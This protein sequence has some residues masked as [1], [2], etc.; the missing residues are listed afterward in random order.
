MCEGSAET[1]RKAYAV[2]PLPEG[3]HRRFPRRFIP[4]FPSDGHNI[5]MPE[6]TRKAPPCRMLSSSPF[7]LRG[8]RRP[9]TILY[10]IRLQ[11]MMP[12]ANKISCTKIWYFD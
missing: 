12:Q 2:C 1:I 10:N 9:P 7:I 5:R 4:L 11:K 3:G 8:R 6:F